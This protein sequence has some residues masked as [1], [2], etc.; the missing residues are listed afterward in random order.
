[1]SKLEP[2]R[3]EYRIRID[4]QQVRDHLP[5]WRLFRQ[6]AEHGYGVQLWL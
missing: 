4:P 1:M 3:L 2:E 6:G 5:S